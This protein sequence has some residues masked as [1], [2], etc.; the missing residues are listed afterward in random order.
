MGNVIFGYRNLVVSENPTITPGDEVAAFPAN[1]LKIAHPTEFWRY[2]TLASGYVDFD[3]GATAP[4]YDLICPLYTTASPIRNI[5]TS[6]LKPISAPSEWVETGCSL[7]GIGFGDGYPAIS[8]HAQLQAIDEDGS[9]GAHYVQ[10]VYTAPWVTSGAADY[11]VV[12]AVIVTNN[13]DTSRNLRLHCF[14]GTDFVRVNID[15]STSTPSVNSTDNSGWTLDDYSLTQFSEATNYWLLKVLFT[16]NTDPATISFR[17]WALDASFNGSYAGDGGAGP[18]VDFMAPFM[19]LS[20]DVD[21]YS[22]DINTTSIAGPVYQVLL[23]DI[24][25][26]STPLL[27]G[28]GRPLA[29]SNAV[30]IWRTKYG[31]THAL[32][33]IISEGDIG[34]TP[35]TNRRYCR[36]R[37]YD[38]NNADSQVDVSNIYVGPHWQP[39]RNIDMGWSV[40]FDNETGGRIVTGSIAYLSEEDALADGMQMAAKAGVGTRYGSVADGGQEY[41]WDKE[42]ILLIL[43][44]DEELYGQEMIV[45]GYLERFQLMNKPRDRYEF[46]FTV[47]EV[48][49]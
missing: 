8:E 45:Y 29:A 47:K 32:C 7:V 18:F 13:T 16:V 10:Q 12:A 19:A 9:T 25:T 37:L 20:N 44:P 21:I 46:Q 4:R 28:V 26:F 30:D 31:W 43:N 49:P 1:N 27:T 22:L 35:P 38:P 15:H 6:T 41:R 39:S 3:F 34:G 42:P 33:T 23:D 24:A 17:L 40:T 36:V 11:S 2:D 48:L 14:N 5:L